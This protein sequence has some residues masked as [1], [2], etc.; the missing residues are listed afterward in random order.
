MTLRPLSYSF[1]L[2]ALASM[3]VGEEAKPAAT[4]TPEPT[5]TFRIREIHFGLQDVEV[6]TSSSRF[7][8]YRALPS[9]FFID[10]MR[11][12]GNERFRYDVIAHNVLQSDA[13]YNAR[14]EPKPFDISLDFQRITHQ[15]GN[16]G[17]TLLVQDTPNGFLISD[18]LQ[19]ANQNAITNQFAKN[20][21]GVNF[22]FLN[23]LIAPEIAAASR[24]DLALTRDRGRID[25]RLTPDEKPFQI[26]TSYFQERRYGNRAAGTS[27]GFGNVVETGEPIE[28][29]TRDFA[30]TAE[31][32]PSWGVV[33]AGIRYNR[34]D[35]AYQ[36]Q[37]FDN[38][39]RATDSTDASAYT[40]PAS[41]SIA[42]PAF[43][44]FG[45]P[46]D[47]DALTGNAG[48]IVKLPGQTRVTAD[49]SLSRWE[50][51]S[52]FMPY[53]SNTAIKSP[54][55]ASDISTLPAASLNGKIDVT[56]L[57]LQATSRPVDKLSLNAR[58]R[59]YDLDNK[60]PRLT[61]PGYV[62]FDGVWE[63]IPRIS[64]PYSNK[65]DR[66]LLSASYDIGKANLE[67]GY[68]YDIWHR[69][70]RE[71]EKTTEGTVFGAF[72]WQPKAWALVRLSAEHGN[73]DFD[74][75]YDTE[76]S[77]D[78]S[79]VK[80]GPLANLPE[81]RR[82]DQA[83]RKSDRI[84]GQLQLTPTD[85]TTI[86]VVYLAGKD[87]Y[88]D[89]SFGLLSTNTSGLTVDLDY[90]PTERVSVY[91]YGAR[92][93]FKNRQKG[94][95]SGATPSTSPADD[96]NSSVKDSV[97]TLGG[98]CTVVLVKD[99]LDFKLTGS[100]QRVN[101]DNAL[102]SPAGGTPDL[103]VSIPNY[104]DTKIYSAGGELAYTLTH[105]LKLSLGGWYEEY[106]L[107]DSATSTIAYYEP[108]GLFLAASNGDYRAH[109]LYGRLSYVW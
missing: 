13:H 98:G 94:R 45:L 109:V 21:A 53:S 88:K 60:T 41:G 72:R 51:D 102:D 50:Q 48:I 61:F 23:S 11:F 89:S 9:G 5:A 52:P 85:K 59:R 33:R 65:T 35:N 62:R 86:A 1:A 19:L 14:L 6:N 18:T 79:Q 76:E 25:V 56:S 90:S 101:G 7:R 106:R 31:W 63:D 92:E 30:T 26:T 46:P 84:N 66:A 93:V 104:D 71:T 39:F 99:R 58:Y 82:F 44:R 67:A 100:Y 8:E 43:G 37:V 57:S 15:F 77:E 20:K 108:G 69:T 96:W 10:D 87:N 16:D 42:G 17:R 75:T 47:N 68:R 55:V 27:F 103:A 4:A 73:R 3:A 78:A 97:D 70:F 95:Q 81:L 28:Y 2:L 80:P 38:P 105:S 34:F 29:R 24:I 107:N 22:N 49:A 54:L 74:G 83:A 12:A 64:V 36:T 40:A 91:A 32:D